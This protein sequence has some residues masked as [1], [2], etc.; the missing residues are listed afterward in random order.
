[1]LIK[2]YGII[3]NVETGVTGFITNENIKNNLSELPV[4]SE[5]FCRILDIDYEKE[6]LDLIIVPDSKKK[7]NLLKDN[8]Y[9]YTLMQEH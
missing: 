2:D 3:L 7:E 4:E 9:N 1:M 8:S 5:V 6:I